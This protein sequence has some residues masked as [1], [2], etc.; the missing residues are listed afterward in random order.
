[1]ARFV[2]GF[3]GLLL[4]AGGIAVAQSE[5]AVVAQARAGG[6][7]GEQADGYLGFASA[8]STAV[9]Q[10]VDAINIKRRQIYTDIA[11][12]QGATVQEVAAARGCDQLAK[13]V[14]PGEAYKS[15]ANWAV[16]QGNAPVPLPAVCK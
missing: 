8:P 5:D 7:V 6:A 10:A 4:M 1:M 3:A 16:R 13:R 2:I 11:G 12:S 9:R 15:G 14:A